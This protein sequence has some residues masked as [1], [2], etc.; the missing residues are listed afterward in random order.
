MGTLKERI[1]AGERV[2]GTFLQIGD[3]TLLEIFGR[4]GADFAIVD[5]EHGSAARDRLDHLVRA[6]DVVG[7]PLIARVSPEELSRA[8]QMLDM[9]IK[10][11]LVPRVTSCAQAKEAV[12][13]ARYGPLGD[14]GA[15]SGIR[16]SDY[17]WMDWTEHE[18]R[19]EAQTIVGIGL[20]GA[21][22]LAAADEIAGL[23]GV[24]FIFIGVFDLARSLG[25]PGEVEHP[26]VIDALVDMVT[27]TASSGVAVSTWAPDVEV[28]RRWTALGVTVLAVNTDMLLWRSACCDMLAQCRALP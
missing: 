1:R 8:S 19:A 18:A 12:R 26:E 10:G 13:V 25:H 15:C 6:G 20:E 22:G 4:A 24:D 28:A 27:R 17:G 16:A 11:L 2:F 23:A 3:P 9:G 14:R 7:L 5:F 21:E